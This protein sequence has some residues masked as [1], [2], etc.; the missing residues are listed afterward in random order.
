MSRPGA[1]RATYED[2]CRVPAGLIAQIIHGQL[3]TLPRPDPRCCLAASS[4][5]VAL[6]R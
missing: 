1:Q 2:L 4:L 3:I 6:I 5:T